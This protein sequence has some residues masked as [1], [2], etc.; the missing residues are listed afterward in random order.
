MVGI[1]VGLQAQ[2]FERHTAE[3]DHEGKRLVVRNGSLPERALQTGLGPIS[4]RQPR[5][6]DRRQGQQF[7]SAILPPYLRRVASIENDF[8]TSR[9]MS[10]SELWAEYDKK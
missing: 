7:T 9:I 6:N 3:R 10:L 1:E 2:R 5:V 8:R 4:V